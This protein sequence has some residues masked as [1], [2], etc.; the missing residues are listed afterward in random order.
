MSNLIKSVNDASFELDVL[1]SDIPVLVDF[2]APWCNPCLAIAPLLEKIAQD[3]IG[4]LQVVKVNVD[5]NRETPAQY[6]V[7]NIPTLL[8]FKNGQLAASHVGANGLL[9]FV[10]KNLV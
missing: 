7:R 3:N 4:K 10:S 8:M 1:E 5:E 9:E 2:W 6:G